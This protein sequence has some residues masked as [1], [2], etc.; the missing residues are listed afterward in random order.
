MEPPFESGVDRRRMAV[1]V[2]PRRGVETVAALV[3]PFGPF[4]PSW[5]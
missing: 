2:A 3:L 5:T 4:D 1:P